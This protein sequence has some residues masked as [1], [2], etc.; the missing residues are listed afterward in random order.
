MRGHE[1]AVRHGEEVGAWEN[2]KKA[3]EAETEQTRHRAV[4]A[5]R[6]RPGLDHLIWIFINS[7]L[8]GIK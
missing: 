3:N 4:L 5:L 6:S 1:R 2:R 7:I 8:S